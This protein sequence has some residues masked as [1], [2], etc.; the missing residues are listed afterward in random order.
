MDPHQPVVHGSHLGREHHSV[1]R[2]LREDHAR[3]AGELKGLSDAA[4][5]GLHDADHQRTWAYA[6]DLPHYFIRRPAAP[7]GT[8]TPA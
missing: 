8:D 3:T 1:R 7:S 2:H 4:I 5:H 6:F